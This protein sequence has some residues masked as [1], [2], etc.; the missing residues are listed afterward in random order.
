[1]TGSGWTTGADGRIPVPAPATMELLR[2]FRI[3]HGETQSELT[4]PTG[5]ALMHGFNAEAMAS[6]PS[7]TIEAIGYGAGTRELAHPNVT[8]AILL[9]H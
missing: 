4:T 2:G 7:G 3:R 1:M 8:R 5:A 9:C 6:M